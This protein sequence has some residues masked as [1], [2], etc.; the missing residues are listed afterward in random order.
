MKVAQPV[1][2]S[3]HFY[4]TAM[5]LFKRNSF[6]SLCEKTFYDELGLSSVQFSFDYRLA[7]K[8]RPLILEKTV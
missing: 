4:L 2:Y 5:F 1:R 3:S 6:R 8:K 7:F